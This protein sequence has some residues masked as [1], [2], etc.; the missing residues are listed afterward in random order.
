MKPGDKVV[1]NGK[2]KDSIMKCPKAFKEIVVISGIHIR[3]FT[4]DLFYII[5]GYEKAYDGCLQFFHPA[6]LIPLDDWKQAEYMVEELK[7]ELEVTV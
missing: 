6:H 4:N 5:H 2:C 7:E 3:P 1:Y